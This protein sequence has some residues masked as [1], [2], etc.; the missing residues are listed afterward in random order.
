[1]DSTTFA[2]GFSQLSLAFS[3]KRD[4]PQEQHDLLDETWWRQVRDWDGPCWIEAVAWWIGHKPWMP[5]V[6]EL[7]EAYDAFLTEKRRQASKALPAPTRTGISLEEYGY[8]RFTAGIA[9]GKAQLRKRLALIAAYR[10]DNGLT[11]HHSIPGEVWKGLDVPTADDIRD[12]IEEMFAHHDRLCRGTEEDALT[13]ADDVA[14]GLAD[15]AE[16]APAPR[17][18][19]RELV[20]AQTGP[21][22]PQ[23]H[24]R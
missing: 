17:M 19:E 8:G 10:T 14:R 3:P 12:V 9:G 20:T 6:S 22:W 1:M 15:E 7:R 21:V 24:T 18:P 13:W 4:L 2:A 5:K 16:L 11:V 23:E